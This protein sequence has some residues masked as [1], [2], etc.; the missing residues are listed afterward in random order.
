MTVIASGQA[1]V[2]ARFEEFGV[3]HVL[4]RPWRIEDLVNMLTGR[5]GCC[6]ECGL[7]LPLREPRPGEEA[8]SWECAYCG[9]RYRAV[10]DEDFPPDMRQ[11]VR[12][13]E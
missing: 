7:Q 6:V 5:I 11:N 8:S 13:V 10:M 1:Q 12:P 3:Q 4:P 2:S 9:S